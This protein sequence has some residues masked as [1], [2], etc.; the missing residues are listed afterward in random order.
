[1]DL[2]YRSKLY[3]KNEIKTFPPCFSNFPGHRT[4]RVMNLLYTLLREDK[5]A[6]YIKITIAMGTGDATMLVAHEDSSSNGPMR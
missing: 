6:I 3:K 4:D 5:C 2:P 1:M